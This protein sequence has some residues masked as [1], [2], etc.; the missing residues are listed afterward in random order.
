MNIFKRKESA[1]KLL[2]AIY[3]QWRLLE[4]DGRD[5]I[6]DIIASKQYADQFHAFLEGYVNSQIAM[7]IVIKWTEVYYKVIGMD[8]RQY[9]EEMMLFPECKINVLIPR[10]NRFGEM[11]SVMFY[12]LNG[13]YDAITMRECPFPAT[14]LPPR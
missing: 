1:T 9:S 13:H 4:A 6:V 8:C 5:P 7:P 3:K 11:F 10:S 2:D 14:V 12:S